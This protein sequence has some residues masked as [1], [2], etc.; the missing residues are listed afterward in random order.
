M[1]SEAFLS[2]SEKVRSVAKETHAIDL[3]VNVGGVWHKVSVRVPEKTIHG[4]RSWDQSVRERSFG[5]LFHRF[6]KKLAGELGMPA[7]PYLTEDQIGILAIRRISDEIRKVEITEVASSVKP[8]K[9]KKL[10]DNQSTLTDE[11]IWPDG[12]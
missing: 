6:K 5:Y 10:N 8:K 4:V 11:P 2:T 9:N 7:I 1:P 3:N 12:V